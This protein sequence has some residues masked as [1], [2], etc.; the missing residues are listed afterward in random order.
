[1]AKTVS[2]ISPESKNAR[3]IL[4]RA[5]ADEI[6]PAAMAAFADLPGPAGRRRYV[7]LLQALLSEAYHWAAEGNGEGFELELPRVLREFADAIDSGQ[8]AALFAGGHA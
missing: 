7:A 1:M 8:V 3:D 5:F 6:H 2:F 4:Q